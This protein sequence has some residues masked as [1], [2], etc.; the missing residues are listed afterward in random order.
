MALGNNSVTTPL[1]SI[2]SSFDT[3]SSFIGLQPRT[4]LKFGGRVSRGK[5]FGRFWGGM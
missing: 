1:N 3:Q 5:A 2:I 4:W